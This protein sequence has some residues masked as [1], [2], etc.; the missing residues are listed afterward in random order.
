MPELAAAFEIME[1]EGRVFLLSRV[2]TQPKGRP[3][4]TP[5]RPSDSAVV[6]C[7]GHRVGESV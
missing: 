3:A 2:T 1:G 7:I 4:T 5:T 6:A